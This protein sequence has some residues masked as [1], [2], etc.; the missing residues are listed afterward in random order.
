MPTN[1]ELARHV[2]Q[3]VGLIGAKR[4]AHVRDADRAL[5]GSVAIASD[6]SAAAL[7]QS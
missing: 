4:G 7:T 6:K 2:A 3:H 1:L 5:R